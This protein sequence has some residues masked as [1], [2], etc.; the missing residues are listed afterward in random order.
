MNE[1]RGIF[2]ALV[3]PFTEGGKINAE[4]IERLVTVNL[5]KGVSGFYIG[6]STAE[7]FLLS[8][9]ERK[10]VLETV[11]K[12][13]Q[14]KAKVIANIGLF[15]TE[16]GID[17][18][19]HADGLG[20]N[21][22]SSVPPFYF[23][24]T[25]DEYCNYYKDILDAVSVPM[26]IYNVPAM[27]GIQFSERDFGRFFENERIIGVK[28]TSYDLYLLQRLIARYPEKLIFIGHDEIFLS[29][30]AA[31]TKAAIG[32]TMCFMPEKYIRIQRHF[33]DQ[34]MDKALKIQN[35]V[36][37]IIAVLMKIGVFKGVKAALEFQGIHCGHCRR[38]FQPLAADEL[39]LLKEVL[40]QTGVIV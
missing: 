38:P 12:N 28:Y 7:S 10:F 31:G 22:I 19:K 21:A 14:G 5:E 26:I 15:S 2:P 20:V 25:I 9:E 13:V 3:T 16:Q 35:E 17:L 36:N 33:N 34:N 1:I 6:G 24:Y 23:K 29:A 27:S 40:L 32:S 18:A 8:P 11:I 4:A 39:R 37:Q 30:L